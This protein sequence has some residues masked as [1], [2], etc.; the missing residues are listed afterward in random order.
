MSKLFQKTNV[1]HVVVLY[2]LGSQ[3]E[4]NQ[5]QSSR[6]SAIHS[7]IDVYELARLCMDRNGGDPKNLIASNACLTSTLLN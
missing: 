2:G 4:I 7:S 3:I 1:W 6:V 5:L